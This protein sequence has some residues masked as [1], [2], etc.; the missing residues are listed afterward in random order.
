MSIALASIDLFVALF[1]LGGL[2][3]LALGVADGAVAGVSRRTLTRTWPLRVAV[4]GG[5][6]L[7]VAQLSVW[8]LAGALLAGLAGRRLMAAPGDR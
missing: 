5:V 4:V 3:G 8:A 7:A 2:I 1:A 6:L